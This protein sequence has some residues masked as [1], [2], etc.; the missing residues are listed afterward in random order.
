M[1]RGDAWAAGLPHSAGWLAS[2]RQAHYRDHGQMLY[3]RSLLV[4]HNLAHQG[5]LAVVR[6]HA[7][8]PVFRPLPPWLL[9]VHP[10]QLPAA[11]VTEYIT[12]RCMPAAA[13]LMHP[14]DFHFTSLVQQGGGH[15]RSWGCWTCPT[16]TTSCSGKLHA[17]RQAACTAMLRLAA[18]TA[19]RQAACTDMPRLASAGCVRPR[20]GRPDGSAAL[21]PAV[22]ERVV[23]PAF[24]F[25]GQLF[26][27]F[28][29]SSCRSLRDAQN[30]SWMMNVLKAG[31]IASHRIVAVSNQ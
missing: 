16:P 4:V 18:C 26:R 1:P 7:A 30:G 12:Q 29:A 14:H 27:F 21:P 3:A 31:A 9:D 25:A 11:V 6:R 15:L 17:Q 28:R 13:A 22:T 19:S 5:K 20:A 10:K 24:T 2:P 23:P 8:M